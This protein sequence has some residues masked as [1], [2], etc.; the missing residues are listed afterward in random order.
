MAGMVDGLGGEEVNQDVNVQ[1]G[2]IITQGP[3][4]GAGTIFGADI[5]GTTS[6]SGLNLFATGSGT[7]GRIRNA[8]GA[9]LPISEGSPAMYGL[10]MQVGTVTTDSNGIGDINLGLTFANAT[11]SLS[12]TPGST[13]V[14]A[15]NLTVIGSM[16]PVV[17]GLKVTSGTVFYGGDTQPYDYFAVGLI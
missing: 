17:S 15:G 1:T 11:W 8:D 7:F 16:I 14:V 13:A 9:L 3:I 5:V 6:I 12:L 2:S 10:T 4:S